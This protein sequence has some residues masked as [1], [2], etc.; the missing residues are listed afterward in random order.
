MAFDN[1]SSAR[2]KRAKNKRIQ[3][4]V[5]QEQAYYRAK[6]REAETAKRALEDQAFLLALPRAVPSPAHQAPA[7]NLTPED[8]AAILKF[9][10]QCREQH[11]VVSA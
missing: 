3:K 2:R 7:L 10:E 4:G 9:A 5:K 1:S 6:A 8:I 11:R